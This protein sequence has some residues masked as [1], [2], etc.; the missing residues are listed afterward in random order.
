[1]K[2]LL[3]ILVA[4]SGL[5]WIAVL[6]GDGTAPTIRVGPWSLDLDLGVSPRAAAAQGPTRSGSTVEPMAAR[7]P[8][9]WSLLAGRPDQLHQGD[10]LAEA[11]VLPTLAD[12]DEDARGLEGFLRRILTPLDA[13]GAH[14]GSPGA[15]C[16]SSVEMLERILE[17]EADL[18]RVRLDV[19]GRGITP[20]VS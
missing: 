4:L 20:P 8:S 10:G 12:E 19:L 11:W 3:P 2:A 16:D 5:G 18:D 7:G 1:M 17:L 14:P 9:A 15:A 6:L 13:S